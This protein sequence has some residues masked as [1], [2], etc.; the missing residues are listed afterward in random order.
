ML[1]IRKIKE[2]PDAIKA[3][4]GLVTEDRKFNGLNLIASVADNI[5]I[6]SID[7]YTT[8]G[9]IQDS[10]MAVDV[11]SMIKKTKVKTPSQKT[12]VMNLSGG[13]QQKVAVSKWLMQKPKI[14]IFDEPT[15]GIDVGAKYEIYCLMNELKAE[16]V[17]IIMI[18]SELPE[19]LGVSDRVVVFRQGEITGDMPIEEANQINI[20]EKATLG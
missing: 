20:M 18:S 15:R 1:D 10:K 14:L 2:N 7:N 4:I 3:G 5:A 17:A 16:G 12:L 11:D 8:F 6:A 9:M 19:I 13:N